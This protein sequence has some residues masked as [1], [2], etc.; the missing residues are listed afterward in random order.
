MTMTNEFK[1]DQIYLIAENFINKGYSDPR[2]DEIIKSEEHSKEYTSELLE[3]I[4]KCS[5]IVRE[6]SAEL[7]V[8]SM[9]EKIGEIIGQKLSN[10]Y[11]SAITRDDL[12]KIYNYLILNCE[13]SNENA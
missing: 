9:K 6:A 5:Q 3:Y 2:I 4:D 12:F 8:R 1:L 13:K 10:S 11:T 7:T